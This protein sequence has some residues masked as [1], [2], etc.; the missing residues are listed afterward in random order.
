MVDV[1]MPMTYWTFRTADYRDAFTYTDDSVSRL[2]TRLHDRNAAVH[3]I[4]GI[5][6]SSTPHDYERFLQAVGADR[7]VGWSVYDYNT[8]ASSAW[9]RLRSGP[10]AAR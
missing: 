5:A 4:G 7:A 9:P 6:D 10:P 3:P 8:T 1:W 2:R